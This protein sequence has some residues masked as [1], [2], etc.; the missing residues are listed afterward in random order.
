MSVFRAYDIRGRYPQE[1][2]EPLFWKIG[3]ATAR[4]LQARTVVVGRDMRDS[5]A[6]LARALCQGLNQGGAQVIDIGMA[7]TPM[8]YFATALYKADA[9]AQVTASHNATDYNGCKLCGPG[10]S[11]LSYETG[12]AEIEKRVRGNTLTPADDAGAVEPREVQPKYVAELMKYADGIDARTV[13]VDAGNGVM[14]AFLPAL[15]A[16]LPCELIPL[17]FE[18]DGSFPHHEANPIEPENLEALIAKVKA[19]GADLGVAFDGDGDRCVFVDEKG[20][21]VP[22]DLVA[23]LLSQEVL[24]RDPG[25]AVVLDL[26]C[27]RAVKDEIERLGGVPVI[28]RV[29]HS[30]IKA[31]MREHDAILGGELSGHFYF[32]EMHYA[33]NAEM[34]MLAVL[35][36]LGRTGQKLSELVA[37]LKRYFATGEIN[38]SVEDPAAALQKVEDALRSEVTEV[39]HLDGLSLAAEHWWCT[40]RPSNTDPVVRLTVET[41]APELRDEL[42]TRIE[43]MLR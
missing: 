1:I 29:G 15:F 26:R 14:G 39:Q 20:A 11:P 18:P 34:A 19:T 40:L 6:P 13:V 33:D 23:G 35:T 3:V 37:P 22:S 24:A 10:A 4:Q 31:L 32:R 9:G 38:F 43:T 42:R 27:S 2:D 16:K 17:Y 21:A 25:A 12:L 36:L 8:L 30:Y 5:S 41:D 7:S 28:S